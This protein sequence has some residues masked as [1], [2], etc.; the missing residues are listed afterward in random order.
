LIS[1]FCEPSFRHEVGA[2]ETMQVLL[3]HKVPLLG[4]LVGLSS[5]GKA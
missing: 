1:F 3:H 2:L 5:L 4:A